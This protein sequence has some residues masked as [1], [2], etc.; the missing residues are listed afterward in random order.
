VT[1]AMAAG[2]VYQ[3][4]F[5][6]QVLFYALAAFGTLS[7]STRKF[8]PVAIANTFVML[9]AAATLAFYNFVAGRNEVWV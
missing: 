2:P 7:P 9:N 1:S 6:L 5:W 4:I 3:A 8:K